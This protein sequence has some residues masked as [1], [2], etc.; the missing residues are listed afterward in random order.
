MVRDK[1]KKAVEDLKKEE[2]RI[3]YLMLRQ[4][5]TVNYNKIKEF[6]KKRLK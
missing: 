4:Q 5:F 2:E 6:W 3:S 1:L